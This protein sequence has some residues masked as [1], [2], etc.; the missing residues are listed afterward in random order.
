MHS[1]LPDSSALEAGI[2]E[3]TQ[4]SRLSRVQD[5]VRNLLRNSR[6]SSPGQT[7]PFSVLPEPNTPRTHPPYPPG[8]MYGVLT[9]PASPTRAPRMPRQPEVIP[10][11]TAESVNSISTT[12]T[13]PSEAIRG[14]HFPPSGYRHTI[15]R[16]A[17][18]S[19][20]FNTRAVAALDHPDLS[21][22]SLAVYAQRKSE[23]RQR[24]AWKKSKK[25]RG[26]VEVGSSQC[27]LCVLA[28]LLLSAVVA[29][30]VVLAT[31]SSDVT[32]TFHILFVLGI[33]LATVVFAH[34]VVRIFILPRGG[35]GRVYVVPVSERSHRRR[36]R[37]HRPPSLMPP[38]P[39]EPAV[40][41]PA[42][43]IPVHMPT[44][45]VRPDS[46]E[47]EPTIIA[48]IEVIN[49]WDKDI[50]SL[51]N[52]PPAYGRWR[53]SVR[54]NPDLL[55]WQILP[56]PVDSDAPELPSPTYEEAVSAQ[57]TGP[58]SYVTRE[59]PARQTERR[60]VGG[61]AAEARAQSAEPEMV[62][63]AGIGFGL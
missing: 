27:L 39:V 56:S 40:F 48:D 47:A 62:E 1:P 21:D 19:A 34:T 36:R 51:P 25:S 5:N 22:P 41:V 35:Q 52:P 44:D 43:P 59:S 14:V 29:T 37:E 7:S 42:T 38:L 49:G 60:E 46:R 54:A 24:R 11:P 17:H 10:S 9:P 30:Y 31:T 28:A 20:L 8:G 12:S 33:I 32:A 58:P 57:R 6:F 16:M 26:V 50:E 18:Q 15:Q 2:L 13:S 23:T 3:D 45:E 61:E 63:G 4:P 53:G 55:H